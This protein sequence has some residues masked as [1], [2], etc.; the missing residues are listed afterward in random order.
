MHDARRGHRRS[1][2]LHDGHPQ[3][4]LAKRD[5]EPFDAA[6]ERLLGTVPKAVTPSDPGSLRACRW[7]SHGGSTVESTAVSFEL[8]S[9]SSRAPVKLQ[10]QR[11]ARATPCRDGRNERRFGMGR[12]EAMSCRSPCQRGDGNALVA[13]RVAPANARPSWT[14]GRRDAFP[15]FMSWNAHVEYVQMQTK[16]RAFP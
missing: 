4:V 9:S 1:R 7:R 11:R 16:V 3:E 2:R 8:R 10:G 5:Q 14:L 13:P 6:S 15:G 12:G